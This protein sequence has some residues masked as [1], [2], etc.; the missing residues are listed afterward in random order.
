MLDFVFPVL[1]R[2]DAPSLASSD[3]AL[4]MANV[5]EF[6]RQ[7]CI[8]ICALLVPANMISTFQTLVLSGLQR[9]RWQMYWIAALSALYATL[10]VL[11]VVTWF[12]AGVVMVPTFVLLGLALV[13]LGLNGW[14]IAAPQSQSRMIRSLVSWV[15][16]TA[17][18]R[19]LI[20]RFQQWNQLTPQI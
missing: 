2:L 19:A 14:A 9:P 17:P 18:I 8:G 15:G 7:H 12:V 13:C 20:R 3:L 4:N 10:M 16:H 6:S 11:H 1:A 5:A